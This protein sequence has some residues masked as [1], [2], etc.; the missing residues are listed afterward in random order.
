MNTN[1][2]T[3]KIKEVLG[4]LKNLNTADAEYILKQ[5]LYN[6]KKVSTLDNIEKVE[7][8]ISGIK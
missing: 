4:L 2:L 6:I 8:D 7:L 3:T 1:E 5:S